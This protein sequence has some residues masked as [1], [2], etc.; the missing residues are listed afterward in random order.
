MSVVRSR[1]ELV[2]DPFSRYEGPGAAEFLSKLLPASLE[3]LHSDSHV[4]KSSLSVM[5][6]EQGGIIDDCMVTRWGPQS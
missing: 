6:N 4:K 2:T 5:L 3:S 1:T